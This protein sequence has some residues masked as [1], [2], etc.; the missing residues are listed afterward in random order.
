MWE[1]SRQKYS[2]LHELMTINIFEHGLFFVLS[3]GLELHKFSWRAVRVT[4]TCFSKYDVSQPQC[5]KGISHLGHLKS[6]KTT[7]KDVK[8]SSN[9][10]YDHE[11]LRSREAAKYSNTEFA[12]KLHVCLHT[13]DRDL[14]EAQLFTLSTNK[15][16]WF[17][18]R[19]AKY[20]LKWWKTLLCYEF[21]FY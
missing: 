4:K 16:D 8:F 2:K 11:F 14:Y 13:N 3:V 7:E 5:V 10:R 12:F 20:Y 19:K 1:K 18:C 15:E 17:I 21:S 9:L 6:P